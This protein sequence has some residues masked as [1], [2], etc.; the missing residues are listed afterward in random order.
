MTN[1]I[2]SLQSI[3]ARA[4]VLGA[5]ITITISYPPHGEVVFAS[6][7]LDGDGLWPGLGPWQGEG[8]SVDVA[9]ASVDAQFADACAA[10]A[11]RLA[12]ACSPPLVLASVAT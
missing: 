7:G 3:H 9:L 1:Q 4:K 8:E 5:S 12:P 6:A 10:I 2:Q 11:R